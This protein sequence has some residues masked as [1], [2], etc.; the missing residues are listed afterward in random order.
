MSGRTITKYVLGCDGCRT[1]MPEAQSATEARGAAYADGWR[2]PPQVKAD[3]STSSNANDVC[4]A[5]LPT[6]ATQP[7][8][9][10]GP[11]NLSD[12]NRR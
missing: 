2:F 10:R 4:P 5:C 3:G 6:W 8:R 12:R 9:R 11:G 7:S 1:E